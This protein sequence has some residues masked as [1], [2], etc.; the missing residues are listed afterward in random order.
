MYTVTMNAEKPERQR[1][2]GKTHAVLGLKESS[3]EVL[4]FVDDI[5]YLRKKVG[6]RSLARSLGVSKMTELY[7]SRGERLPSNPM[8]YESVKGWAERERAIDAAA[9]S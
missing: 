5:K 2:P 9:V 1:M 6:P 7:W 4:S 8:L 3:H